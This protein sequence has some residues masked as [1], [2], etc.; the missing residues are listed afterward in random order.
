MYKSFSLLE[1]NNLI[2]LR[3]DWLKR[4]VIVTVTKLG[5]KEIFL[6]LISLEMGVSTVRMT[7]TSV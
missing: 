2:Y 4:R 1:Y 7:V 6:L 3:S 5:T